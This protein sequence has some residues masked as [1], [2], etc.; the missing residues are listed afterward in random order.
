MTNLRNIAEWG[1]LFAI[2]QKTKPRV[3]LYQ[4]N[5]IMF[6]KD[7]LSL[8]SFDLNVEMLQAVK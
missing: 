6:D 4:D 8:L 2:A 7:G 5:K 3:L 1:H